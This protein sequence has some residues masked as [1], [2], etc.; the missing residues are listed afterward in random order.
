MGR[1]RGRETAWHPHGGQRRRQDCEEWRRYEDLHHG[2]ERHHH[3]HLQLPELGPGLCGGLG[4]GQAR[5]PLGFLRTLS[6]ICPT[7]T[8]KR[9][10]HKKKKKKKKGFPKKKKKKKKKKS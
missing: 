10:F 6:D 9:G 2:R 4:G 8:I 7:M 1:S 5:V 3:Q